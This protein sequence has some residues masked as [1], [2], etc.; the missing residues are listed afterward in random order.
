MSKSMTSNNG[1]DI[2]IYSNPLIFTGIPPCCT[3]AQL[4]S[5]SSCE[6]LPRLQPIV[7]GGSARHLL[8]ALQERSRMMHDGADNE[9]G[10]A[11]DGVG[12]LL[13]IKLSQPFHRIGRFQ[14]SDDFPTNSIYRDNSLSEH[15]ARI[16][17]QN[18][19]TDPHV[20]HRNAYTH[21]PMP[22]TPPG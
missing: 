17:P 15:H 10:S 6:F 12:H 3:T 21:Y 4:R 13:P 7:V 9:R 22:G 11:E 19:R 20:Y 2:L 1:W 16:I 18:V 5:N 8:V 14:A